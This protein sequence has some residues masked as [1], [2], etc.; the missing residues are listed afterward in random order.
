MYDIVKESLVRGDEEYKVGI[1]DESS[2]GFDPPFILFKP[3]PKYFA[4]PPFPLLHAWAHF[5]SSVPYDHSHIACSILFDLL[6]R[7]LTGTL[8]LERLESGGT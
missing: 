8:R 7:A 1:C 5:L 4:N 2:N 3:L 6:L